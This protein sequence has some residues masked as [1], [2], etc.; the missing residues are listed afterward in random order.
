MSIDLRLGDCLEVMPSLPSTSIDL[1][2]ADLPYGTTSCRWDTIIPLE[3]LWA[4]YRRVIK[5][6]GAVVLTASQPFTSALVMSNPSWFRH[7]WAWIRG[8]R[9]AGY[10][11]AKRRPLRTFEDVL[12][13]GKS[14]PNYYPQMTPDSGRKRTGSSG[15]GN[16]I[17]GKKSYG[18]VPQLNT[19]FCYPTDVINIQ[20]DDGR[21]RVHPTQKPVALMEY[22]I[23]TYSN[24]GDIVLDNTMGS[25]TTGVACLR[26][27][28]R[29]IGIE[30]DAAYF[31]VAEKRINA[32][33]EKYSLLA[34]A[35]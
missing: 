5:P 17:Y 13:F 16:E 11:D 35:Q 1:I 29:F 3:G 4:E 30:K 10:L 14:Q 28:R 32:E 2:L 23:R 7:R 34:Q 21:L 8:K 33:I 20:P 15:S 26:T 24:E 25:G 18:R 6:R 9:K 12:I 31:L 22:L 27:D 19:G